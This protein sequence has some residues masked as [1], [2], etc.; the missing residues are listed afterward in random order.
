MEQKKC[1]SVMKE[2]LTETLKNVSYGG[3]KCRKLSTKMSDEIK[4]RIKEA[5][6]LPPRYK[7]VVHTVLG[8]KRDQDVSVSSESAWDKQTD[9]FVAV[10]FQNNSL[11]CAVTL[12]AVYME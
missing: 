7:C 9:T 3:E 6:L 2:Y 4:T 5:G 12:F 8:E 11:F 1:E 10:A